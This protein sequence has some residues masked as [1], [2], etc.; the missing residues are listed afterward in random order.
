[1]YSVYL[2]G[3]LSAWRMAG[4]AGRHAECGA[5]DQ[6]V[7]DVRAGDSRALVV[8]GEPGVGKTALLEYLA[9][10]APGCRVAR[11]AGVQSEMEL[12]FASL[13]Q[14]CAPILD[15][16]KSLP[17]PQRD[18]LRTAFGIGSGSA[19]NGFL[20]GL[21]VLGLLSHA[22]EERPLVCLIDDAQWLDQASAQVLAFVARRLGAESVGLV[23][24]ARVPG[25]DLT[26]LPQLEVRGLPEADAHALLDSVL[27]SLIDRR[28]QDQ[29]V[30]A[31]K[32][33]SGGA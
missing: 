24:A 15:H 6:L 27:P 13:H 20:I 22:A 8:H 7:E 4:L 32:R 29:I 9:G 11:A 10:H 30:A 2:P 3:D 19:P 33:A 21:A 12:A 23:F 28:V 25:G 31:S 1:M 18:A 17:G 5:L 16:L 26:A 14:L